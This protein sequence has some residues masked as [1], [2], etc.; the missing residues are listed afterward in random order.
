MLAGIR[1]VVQDVFGDVHQVVEIQ[2]VVL[3]LAG[4][5]AAKPGRAAHLVGDD[6]ARQHI[7]LDV[8]VQGFVGSHGLQE[9]L[10]GFLRPLDAH[11]VHRLLGDG[12]GVLLVQDGEGL[13]EAQPVDF[14]AEELDAEAV[15]GADEVV[16]V[17]ALDHLRDAAPHLR[18]GLV[19]EGETEDVRRVDAQD[20][21]D[22]RVTVGECLG[23]AR[24]GP[25]HHAHAA[26]GGLHG[27]RLS[28]V[29]SLEDVFHKYVAVLA[30]LMNHRGLCNCCRVGKD[31]TSLRQDSAQAS[32]RYHFCVISPTLRQ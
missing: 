15:Q 8:S 11:F 10:D 31:R 13:G 32:V 2:G 30:K 1:K 18:R 29:E 23:L 26:L 21:D 14:L 3:H 4:D 22:V 27:L 17:A 25:G 28:A 6:A 24:P 20:V 12:P 19:G 16:V 9:L 7:G 5:V